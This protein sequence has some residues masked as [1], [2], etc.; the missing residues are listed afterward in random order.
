MINWKIY[1]RGKCMDKKDGPLGPHWSTTGALNV[2]QPKRLV[3]DVDIVKNPR[4]IPI[5]NVGLDNF[6]R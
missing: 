4:D 2:F 3:R 5:P 1:P 6:L